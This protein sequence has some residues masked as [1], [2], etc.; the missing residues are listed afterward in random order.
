MIINRS[1]RRDSAPS[2]RLAPA[3]NGVDGELGGVVIDAD[4]DATG[5]R[6]D[7]VDAIGNGFAE[8]L[9]DEVMHVDLVGTA[10]GPIVAAPFL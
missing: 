10:L 4:A 6:A 2:H 3:A 7:V 1:A 8:F 5:I 9:I